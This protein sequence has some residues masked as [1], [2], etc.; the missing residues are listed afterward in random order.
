MSEQVNSNDPKGTDAAQRRYRRM[1]DG[2]REAGYL[3]QSNA[4]G[5]SVEVRAS[6]KRRG[7]SPT[8]R[9]RATARF[10]EAARLAA[11]RKWRTT[12]LPDWLENDE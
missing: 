10:C 5:D 7:R 9:F 3:N 4:N 6:E 2:M 8:L 12:R 1:V 11:G